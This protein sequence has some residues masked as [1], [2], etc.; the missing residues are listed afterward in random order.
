M[1]QLC[2]CCNYA[3]VG[4]IGIQIFNFVLLS[5]IITPRNIITPHISKTH[6]HIVSL[7]VHEH[8]N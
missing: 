7:N 8:M 6:F 4:H 3:A 1:V 5:V 2:C